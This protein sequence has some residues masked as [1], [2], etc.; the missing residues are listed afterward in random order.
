MCVSFFN[1]THGARWC[2]GLKLSERV[3]YGS[4]HG[5]SRVRNASL[6]CALFGFRCESVSTVTA[7][8]FGKVEKDEE[9]K[10]NKQF[11]K[12]KYKKRKTRPLSRPLTIYEDLE[13]FIY[14]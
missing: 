14:S 5:G 1:S 4:F 13:I 7:P 8:V 10:N 11:L 9:K 12:K 2:R 3:V 6:S